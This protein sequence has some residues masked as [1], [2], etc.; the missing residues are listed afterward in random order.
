MPKPRIADHLLPYHGRLELRDPATLEL[1]VIHCTELPTLEEAREMGERRL[2][3]GSGTG[4]SGHYYIDRDGAIYRYV[5]DDRVAHHV[6]GYNQRS[7]GIEL[8]NRGRYPRWFHAG[9]QAM[10]EPYETAQ[11]DSLLGLLRH[12]RAVHAG[13]DK[14]AAHADLDRRSIAAE[15]DPRQTV[16]RRLDPGPRFPWQRVLDHVGLE[17][18]VPDAGE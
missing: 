6:V 12:L 9:H 1:I 3:E 8:V 13:I 16:Q 15:D 7:I 14:L 17:R 18:F 10:T 11:I 5:S 2:Y 4:A